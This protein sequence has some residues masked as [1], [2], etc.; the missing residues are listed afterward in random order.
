MGGRIVRGLQRVVIVQKQIDILLENRKEFNDFV[1]CYR[2]RCDMTIFLFNA[3]VQ[4][5][6]LW[7]T[8]C[9]FRAVLFFTFRYLQ[10]TIGHIF[11]NEY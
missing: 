7:T 1:R 2:Q 11:I 10:K 8:S 5:H 3:V 9:F 6:F 4:I